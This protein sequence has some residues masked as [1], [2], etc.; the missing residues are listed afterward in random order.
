[1]FVL[2]DTPIDPSDLAARRRA[3]ADELRNHRCGQGDHPHMG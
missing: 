2:N 1:M 3:G